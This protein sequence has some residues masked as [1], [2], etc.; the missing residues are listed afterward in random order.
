MSIVSINR[1]VLED[2]LKSVISKGEKIK[3]ELKEVKKRESYLKDLIE[4]ID[5][6]QL[7]IKFENPNLGDKK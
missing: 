1:S 4:R 3:Q 6:G 7:S 5:N 2:E